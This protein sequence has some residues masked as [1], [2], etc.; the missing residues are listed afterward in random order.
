MTKKYDVIIIG[1]GPGGMTAALYAARA[2]LSVLMLDRGIYGGQMNNTGAIDNYPGLPDVTGPELGEKM[3]Q[4]TMKFGS[5]FA[6]G[7]VTQIKLDGDNRIVITD[8]DEY[9]ALVVLIATGAEHKHLGVPGEEEYQGRGV[10]YCAV[11][12][13][14]FFKDEDIAVIGGGDSAI[15]EGLYLAQTA[16]KVTIIHRRDQL[17]AQPVLQKRAFANDKI[18]FIWNAQTEEIIGA[19]NKVIGVKYKDKITGKEK[20]LSV[21]GVFIYVGVQPQTQAFK[22]LDITDEHGWIMTD[23]HMRTKIPG[24][25]ALGD[26]RQKDLRQIATAVGEGSIAGQEAYNYIQSLND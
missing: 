23:D 26:V 17:R 19:E 16:K 5:K 8:N 10:S 6:Y 18:D 13:A 7:E 24:I 12:D 9:V 3:Y 1:A 21:A 4:G 20:I 25:L 11:C 14:A 15:E 22:N 2:N